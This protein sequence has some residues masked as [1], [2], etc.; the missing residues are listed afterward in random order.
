MNNSLIPQGARLF[1]FIVIS[2]THINQSEDRAAAFFKL[3]SLANGSLHYPPHVR[4]RSEASHYENID[5]PA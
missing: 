4:G 3:N 1:R 2:D 5:E